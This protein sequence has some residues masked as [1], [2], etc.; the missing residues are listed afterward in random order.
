MDTEP[1]AH[2]QCYYAHIIYFCIRISLFNPKQPNFKKVCSLKENHQEKRCGNQEM[3][4]MVY[5]L[6]AKNLI[7]KIHV[8]LCCLLHVSHQIHLKNCH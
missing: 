2:V 3:V 1:A 5:G 4:V 7:A 6:M 8:N